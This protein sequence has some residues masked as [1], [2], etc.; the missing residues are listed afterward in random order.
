MSVD[1]VITP[2]EP[3]LVTGANGFIG[4]RVVSTLVHYGFHNLRCLVRPSGN[5]KQLEKIVNRSGHAQIEI[6]SGNLLSTDDCKRAVK[7]VSLIFHL[8]AGIDKSHAGAFMNSVVT[9]RN[10]LE[11]CAQSDKLKRF[12]NV[13]SLSVYS[14]KHMRRGELLN[15]EC[16]VEKHPE[17]RHEAYCYGKI[18]QDELLLEQARRYRVPY[19]IVRPGAV[20][21][22]GKTGITGRIGIDTFGIFLHL[23]GSNKIPLT[24]I[25]NC[26]DAIVLAGIKV[27]VEG[28][29]FNI[30]DD[31]LPRS[32]DFL[33]M[34]KRHVGEFRSISLPYRLTFF[35]CYLWEKY[36]EW[37]EGQLPPVFNRNR[38]AT[39]W[40]GNRYSNEKAKKLLGWTPK[41]PFVEASKRYFQ[42]QKEVREAQ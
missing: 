15:E 40:K 16:E 33:R 30:V 29:V 5:R 9:T 10:L 39:D 12:V 7:D 21:G 23:G 27:G 32:K 3:I 1:T 25:D 19:V 26:A 24:Y 20:Y 17:Q 31:E 4:T 6:L 42:Y 11:V 34:Y 41:I 38:C 18:K 2:A 8:A 37:S 14:N 13:S 22:P 28:Q 36:S 35:L